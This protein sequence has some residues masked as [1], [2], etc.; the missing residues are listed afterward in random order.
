MFTPTLLYFGIIAT[1]FVFSPSS[2]SKSWSSE[3][4]SEEIDKPDGLTPEAIRPKV[5]EN[6][7]V[8]S[9]NHG[10]Y[11]NNCTSNQPSV[12]LG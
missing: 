4:N 1:L 11:F 9:I 3:W 5:K 6:P 12:V 8:V 2:E 7:C 10:V